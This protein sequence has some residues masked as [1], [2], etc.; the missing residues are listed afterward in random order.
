MATRSG[1]V[2][3]ISQARR[4]FYETAKGDI[5]IDIGASSEAYEW[6]LSKTTDLGL[7]DVGDP[8]WYRSRR[9]SGDLPDGTS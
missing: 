9:F 3:A 1:A 7:D 2:D 8:A 5:D 4:N 6:Q